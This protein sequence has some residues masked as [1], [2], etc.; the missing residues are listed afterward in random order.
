MKMFFSSNIKFLRKRRRRTQD[1][2]ASA[3]GM[4]RSTLSG[5]ENGVAQPGVSVLVAFSGYFNVA[6]DTLIKVDLMSLRESQLS[7]LE[8][9]FDVFLK[10]SG[11]RVLVSTVD[12][13]NNENIELVPEKAKAGYATGFSD[14]EYVKELPVFQLP[15]LSREKKYRTFQISGDSMLPVPSGSWVTGE[16]L[17]DWRTIKTGIPCII[18]TRDEG[19]V[20]KIVE[21][22]LEEDK[23]LVLHSLNPLYKPYQISAEAVQEVWVFVHYISNVMP[24]SQEEPKALEQ[25][26]AGLQQEILLIKERMGWRE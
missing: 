8:N 3:L 22:K 24:D 23:N 13:A 25:T 10:G 6:I 11:L 16:F 12:S 15:F 1:D 20:F 26:V 7:Q 4:K 18:V 19:V 5:Y 2:V 9:G 21:N 14:P 17:Q